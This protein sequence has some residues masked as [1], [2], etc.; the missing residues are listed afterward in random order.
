MGE[1]QQLGLAV[2]RRALPGAGDPS[3]ADLDSAVGGYD[4]AEAGRAHR[5]PRGA[6]DH[7]EGQGRAL[8]LPVQGLGDE[9]AHVG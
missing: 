8:A 4:G 3:P 6:L 9:C 1:H 5:L 2:D 7:G